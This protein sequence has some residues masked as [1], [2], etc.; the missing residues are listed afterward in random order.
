MFVLGHLAFP[1]RQQEVL[2]D[3][4]PV[5]QESSPAEVLLQRLTEL[6]FLEL[7]SYNGYRKKLLTFRLGL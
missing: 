3:F 7:C 2:H 1:R 6:S 5:F 4:I